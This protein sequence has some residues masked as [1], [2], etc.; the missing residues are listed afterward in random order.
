MYMITWLTEPP[1]RNGA[2][3]TRQTDYMISVVI[4]EP[5]RS[6]R[7]SWQ[8]IADRA[9]DMHCCGA[10]AQEELAL[11]AAA[12]QPPTVLLL[13]M[14]PSDQ[15]ILF[16]KKYRE[17]A[18]AT[19]ILVIASH[20]ED[21][22]LFA[23]LRAGAQGYLTQAVFPSRLEDAIREV[24]RGEAP[25]GKGV[26]RRLLDSFRAQRRS[27]NLS[28]REREVYHLLCQGKNY[29]EIGDALFVSPNTVR[30]HLKNIYRKLGVKSRH[31]AMRLA[32]ED[33]ER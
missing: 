27:D 8:R 22:Q 4:V 28:E 3:I 19:Q 23:A 9:N 1:V 7:Q 21:E 33:S 30:F 18:P 12:S 13:G 17:V 10:Y 25:L 2:A 6:L 29:R 20:L 14:R 26:A 5:K 16:I 32:Y 15:R 24:S 11:L 31:E